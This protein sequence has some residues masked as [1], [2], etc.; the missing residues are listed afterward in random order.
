MD[1]PHAHNL[2]ERLKTFVEDWNAP[3]MDVYD[4]L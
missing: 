2:R 3:E 1:E 4:A